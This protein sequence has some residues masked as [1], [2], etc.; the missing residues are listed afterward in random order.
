MAMNR[1]IIT[2]LLGACVVLAVLYL[3][4]RAASVKGK[5]TESSVA[6]SVA[7]NEPKQLP[8]WFWLAPIIA[9]II[10]LLLLYSPRGRNDQAS[11]IGVWD[12]TY[13]FKDGTEEKTIAT[14][15]EDGTCVIKSAEDPELNRSGRWSVR[16]GLFF[17]EN[18][19][20]NGQSLGIPYTMKGDTVVM[21]WGPESLTL[22]R[23]D[24]R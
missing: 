23:I 22:V 4:F 17:E 10:L 20:R 15:Y 6:T 9:L 21:K 12:A 8:R 14:F 2:L 1:G 7:K 18:V 16:N 24:G 3:R 11:F 5:Q 19:K 13:V